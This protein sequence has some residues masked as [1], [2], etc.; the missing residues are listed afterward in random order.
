[1]YAIGPFVPHPDT[2]L[3]DHPTASIEQTLRTIAVARI[4]LGDVHIPAT[5]ALQAIHP[6]GWELGLLAGANVIM[7]L[8]TPAIY[9]ED[10]SI[11]PNPGRADA[12]DRRAERSS[13]DSTCW[14][15]SRCWTGSSMKLSRIV[16]DVANTSRTIGLHRIE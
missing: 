10:Y 4:I 9:R 13:N 11:Y 2:P 15:T 7:S 8:E 5:T 1:M 6:R 14:S 16:A 12:D 3:A